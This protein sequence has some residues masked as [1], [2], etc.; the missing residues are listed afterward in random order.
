[1]AK[2]FWTKVKKEIDYILGKPR[3]CFALHLETNSFD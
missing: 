2:S 3:A 1:M